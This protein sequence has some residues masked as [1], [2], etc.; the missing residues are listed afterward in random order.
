VTF[1]TGSD[2]ASLP[3]QALGLGTDRPR[4]R[5]APRQ[6]QIK[7]LRRGSATILPRLRRVKPPRAGYGVS[8]GLTRAATKAQWPADDGRPCFACF[9]L[10]RQCRRRVRCHFQTRGA[11]R[12]IAGAACPEQGY[13]GNSRSA[14][15]AGR[16]VSAHNADWSRC[17]L[18]GW[19]PRPKPRPRGPQQAD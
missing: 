2:T 16:P 3:V 12:L 18:G 7:G 8:F 11:A 10:G 14:A 17:G 19:P 4:K 5:F 15:A 1:Q 9:C 6:P 13:G